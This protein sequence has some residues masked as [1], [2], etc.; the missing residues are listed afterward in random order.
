MPLYHMGVIFKQL[1]VELKRLKSS[2]YTFELNA[3]ICDEGE[4]STFRHDP[5]LVALA[6]SIHVANM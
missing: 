4:A 2:I 6:L 3:L 5:P 1:R